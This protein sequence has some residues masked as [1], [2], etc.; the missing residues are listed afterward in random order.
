MADFD[1]FNGDA[2]GICALHQLRLAEPRDSELVTGVKR[3]IALLERIRNATRP[4]D[5]VTVL[6]VS[7]E[8]NRGAL[9]SILAKGARVKWFDHHHPGELPIHPAFDPC[10]DLSPDVC[11]SLIV[12]RYL[13][14]RYRYW[15]IVALFGDGLSAVAK[16]LAVECGLAGGATT[17]LA[18][19]GEAIN[20]NAY[21]ESVGDLLIAPDQLYRKISSYEDPFEFARREP[22]AGELAKLMQSDLAC[23]A[24]LEPVLS[25]EHA[26]AFILPD[27][28]WARRISGPFATQTAASNPSRAVAVLTRKRSGD[29][30]ASVRTPI[31]NRVGAAEFCR[32]YPTGGGRSAAGGINS[33][34]SQSIGMF[35]D[36]FVRTFGDRVS[37]DI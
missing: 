10:V 7:V 13:G 19:L 24:A 4:G 20:Y 29:L 31:S 15:A 33:M 35:L 30:Q 3:D 36:D 5:R 32:R 25:T 2:D 12:D 37:E 28:P 22:L 11:T 23:A 14:G 16:R 27:Q 1:V 21:G 6:D 8:P 26:V 34:E 18:G 9:D 17:E